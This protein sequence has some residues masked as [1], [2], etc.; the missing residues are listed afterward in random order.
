MYYKPEAMVD[1][2]VV[3]LNFQNIILFHIIIC[4]LFLQI[5]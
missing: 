2:V 4:V 3:L 5:N 1:T